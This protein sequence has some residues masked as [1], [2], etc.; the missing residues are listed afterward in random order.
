MRLA[1]V[2]GALSLATD[3][4]NGQAAEQGLRTT[5]LACRLARGE[6][7]TTRQDVYWAGLLRY[8]GCNGFALEEAGFAAG[9]DIGLRAS[10]VRTDLGRPSEFVRAALR[11]VGRGAS[12][13]ARARGVTRLLTSPGAPRA[14]ALAQCDAG[15]HCARKLSMSAAVL[16]TLADSDERFDGRGLPLGKTGDSL[17]LASRCVEVARVAV[18]FLAIGGLPAARAE[19]RRRAGGH[20]DP[21]IVQR[22]DDDADVHCRDLTEGSPWDVF[23]G[24]EPG[25]WLIGEAA[26]ERLFDAFALMADLKSGYFAGH[27]QG[28]AT[29]ARAAALAAGADAGA[30]ERVG[31]AGLLHDLGR[32]AVPTGL[33]E[34]AGPLGVSEWERVRLHSYYTDRVLRRS[35]RLA[36]Y[37]DIA[38]RAHERLDGSGYHRGDSAPEPAA[39]WLAAADVYRACLED[40]P[41][42]RALGPDAA[43]RVL[44]D[45]VAAGRLGRDAVEAVLAAAGQAAPPPVVDGTLT[46]RERDVLRLLVRGLSNKA[47]A[48]DLGISPR[49]VQ[50]HTIHIYGKTG[51]Q[52]R[53]G[54]ALW[55]IERGLYR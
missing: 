2:L 47:I 44:L 16:Q 15:V 24:S 35:D 9:D 6:S 4:A 52:S 40:R 22:F 25:L 55:A 37:A 34:K 54:A 53:A 36:P 31:H 18:V 13:M 46:Q 43:R 29:L 7:T 45:E 10:F 11:D 28:V 50:H 30:A 39:R 42:R 32:V 33:W 51:V 49:T 26:M 12:P 14:H 19:L 20:L 38:G 3:L 21:T 8:L 48:R 23:L 41:Y 27:S 5:V 1:E 17:S